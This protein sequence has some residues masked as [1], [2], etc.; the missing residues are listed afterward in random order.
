MPDLR[1]LARHHHGAP[2][3]SDRRGWNTKIRLVS[4]QLSMNGRTR[5]DL[6]AITDLAVVS[7]ANLATQEAGRTH[8]TAARYTDLRSGNRR[9]ANS[10]AVANVD[11]VVELDRVPKSGLAK[12][13]AIHG[14]VGADLDIIADH[15]ATNLG[16]LQGTSRCRVIG[17]SVRTQHSPGVNPTAL[18]DHSP[19]IHRDIRK[20]DRVIANLTAR[21]HPHTP[22]DGH[23]LT[24]D[25]ARIHERTRMN[26]RCMVLGEEV[27]KQGDECPLRVRDHNTAAAIDRSRDDQ[28]PG[29]AGPIHGIRLRV[30]HMIRPSH[31]Q[32]RHSRK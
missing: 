13:R 6:R 27:L 10:A 1:Q 15:K 3:L 26:P 20:H 11:Q 19:R 8:A 14:R 16:H 30:G 28:D 4:S 7:D 23:A 9:R 18:P 25:R 24:Q 31:I 12:K 5:T 32:W 2:S 21:P 17:K 22:V 29:G